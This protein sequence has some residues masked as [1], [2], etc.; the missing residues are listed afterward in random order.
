MKRWGTPEEISEMV[1]FL[2]SEKSNYING[3]VINID[4]GWLAS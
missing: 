4:G 3:E 1:V 2:L